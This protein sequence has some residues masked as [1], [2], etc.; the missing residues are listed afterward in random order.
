MNAPLPLLY[1]TTFPNMLF[2]NVLVY[3]HPTF[4]GKEKERGHPAPRQGPRPIGADLSRPTRAPARGAPT[5]YGLRRLSRRMVGATLAVA[6]AL[7]PRLWASP[8]ASPLPHRSL[9]FALGNKEPSWQD[10]IVMFLA[11]HG[12]QL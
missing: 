12:Q 11:L 1:S 4:E 9:D 5:I 7:N 10:R 3:H 6:L 2:S 8:P